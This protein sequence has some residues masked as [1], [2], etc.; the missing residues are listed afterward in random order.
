MVEGGNGM[1]RITTVGVATIVCTALWLAKLARELS[2]YILLALCLL[3][4]SVHNW[5]S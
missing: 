3:L 1:V 4:G 5:R 2:C